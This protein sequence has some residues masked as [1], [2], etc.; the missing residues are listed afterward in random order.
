MT[1]QELIQQIQNDAAEWLEMTNVPDQLM[2]GYMANK[3]LRLQEYVEYLEKR[4]EYV[5][6]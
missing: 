4:L 3:I 6:R 5:N 2:I 1:T